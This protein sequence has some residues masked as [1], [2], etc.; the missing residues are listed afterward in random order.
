MNYYIWTRDDEDDAL[1]WIKKVPDSI[2]KKLYR[3]D[4]G[5]LVK[6]WFPDDVVFELDLGKGMKLSDSIPNILSLLIV[7]E[8]LKQILEK[9]SG[10]EF[11]FFLVKIKDQKGNFVEGNYYVANVIGSVDCVDME[12][13]NYIMGKIN[14]DQVNYFKELVLDEEKIQSDLKIFRLQQQTKTI[15]VNEALGVAIL[16][17][18][19]TG[20]LFQEVDDFGSEYRD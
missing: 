20:V 2:Y 3:F 7:S 6:D 19:C 18:G 12:K 4:E 8:K 14:K 15:T 1:A 5:V 9:D 10:A 17:A 11:E 13:S 16:K